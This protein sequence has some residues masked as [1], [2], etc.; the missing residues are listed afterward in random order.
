MDAET[1]DVVL[2]ASIA[3]LENR[4]TLLGVSG[5]EDRLQ[6]GVQETVAGLREAGIHVW[7]LTGDKLET[8]LNIAH[9]CGL[10]PRR[11]KVVTVCSMKF[12]LDQIRRPEDIGIIASSFE[13]GSSLVLS[14][15]IVALLRSNQDLVHLLSK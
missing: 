5:I 9:S 1:R 6:D 15:A 10:F 8:A 4:L 13:E 2:A 11:G 3:H 12:Q 14:P 7:L